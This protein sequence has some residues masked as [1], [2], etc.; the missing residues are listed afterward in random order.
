MA[1]REMRVVVEYPWKAYSPPADWFDATQVENCRVI[2]ADGPIHPQGQSL[3]EIRDVLEEAGF[4]QQE[5]IQTVQTHRT[6]RWDPTW[7]DLRDFYASLARL[8]AQNRALQLNN[9]EPLVVDGERKVLVFKRW[10]EGGNQAIV[11]LNF[12]PAQQHIEVT[13]PRAGIWHEWTKDYDENFGDQAKQ[14]VELPP[15]GGKVW[16][17]A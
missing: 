7:R 11:G 6:G 10:D 12:A 4:A 15:S 14:T 9:L 8:R 16:I 13:F 17:A 1:T 3:A 2:H 5:P